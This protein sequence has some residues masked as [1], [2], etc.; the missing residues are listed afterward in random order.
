MSSPRSKRCSKEREVAEL[1]FERTT[2]SCGKQTSVSYFWDDLSKAG[3]IIGL[4]QVENQCF[5]GWF[6]SEFKL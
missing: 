4:S 2:G 5:F 1:G 3:S 6:S